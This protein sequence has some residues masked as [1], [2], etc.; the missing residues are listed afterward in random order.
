MD[1]GFGI[2]D[3]SIAEYG[4]VNK[5]GRGAIGTAVAD[6][7][8]QSSVWVAPTQARLHDIVSTDIEDVAAGG[9]ARTLRLYGLPDWDTAEVNE[10]IALDGTIDVETSNLY[11]IIH[12]MQ[13]LTKGTTDVNV[14]SITATAQGDS[15]VTAQISPSE[16]QTQMAVYGI[17]STQ[18]AY[19]GGYYISATKPAQGADVTAKLKVNPEPADELTNFLTKHSL[20]VSTDG[21]SNEHHEWSVAYRVEGPA[22][23]KVEVE[24]TVASTDVSAGFDAVLRDK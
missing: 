21:S 4:V 7:W 14:G 16:G 3:G 9:G 12:R 15:S 22:I 24:S 17:P 23:I 5:F 1:V 8:D 20:G 11:V 10:D 2:I 6:V 13:V 19:L 18:L